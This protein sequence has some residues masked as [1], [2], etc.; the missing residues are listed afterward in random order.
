V[1]HELRRN[2]FGWELLRADVV[3]PELKTNSKQNHER[4]GYGNADAK[5]IVIF[6]PSTVKINKP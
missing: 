5:L 3:I 6:L 2:E 4:E 1:N